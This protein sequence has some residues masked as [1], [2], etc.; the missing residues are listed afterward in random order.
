MTIQT[1]R[2]NQEGKNSPSLPKNDYV[3]GLLLK[4]NLNLL[5]I[6]KKP[7]ERNIQKRTKMMKEIGTDMMS[8]SRF[9]M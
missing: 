4:S 9:K 5:S 2:P 8:M 6:T 1:I 7:G 3:K